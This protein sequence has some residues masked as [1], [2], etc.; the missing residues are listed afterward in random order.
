[1]E[2]DRSVMTENL[3]RYSDSSVEPIYFKQI[4]KI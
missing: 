2:K 4:S 1:M 3:K